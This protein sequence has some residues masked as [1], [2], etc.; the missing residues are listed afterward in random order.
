MIETVSFVFVPALSLPVC[1]FFRGV[2]CVVLEPMAGAPHKVM[3]VPLDV[4]RVQ[5]L[6]AQNRA[7][8]EKQWRAELSPLE[9]MLPEVWGL[10]A[11]YLCGATGSP[12]TQNWCQPLSGAR[13]ALVHT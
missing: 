11:Q 12:K 7:V 4:A 10:V 5:A 6:S 8:L 1:F 13:L 2:L 3:P 9:W